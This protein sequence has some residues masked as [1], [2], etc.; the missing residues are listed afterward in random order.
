MLLRVVWRRV[1][2][3]EQW[4]VVLRD[5][6]GGGGR[7]ARISGDKRVRECRSPLWS[8]GSWT[9]QSDLAGPRWVLTRRAERWG[10]GRL[11]AV[12]DSVA[13]AAHGLRV[14]WSAVP[15]AVEEIAN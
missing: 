14:S 12:E 8:A 4:E 3:K 5:A 13:S 6:L 2:S 7:P 9:E 10:V 15:S 11:A 1:C